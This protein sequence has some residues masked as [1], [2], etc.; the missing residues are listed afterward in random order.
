MDD[1]FNDSGG[2]LQLNDALKKEYYIA[3]STFYLV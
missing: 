3:T 1:F 2:A